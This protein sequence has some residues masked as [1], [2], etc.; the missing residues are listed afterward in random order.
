MLTAEFG[1]SGGKPIEHGLVVEE[2]DIE[3]GAGVSS[4]AISRR[5]PTGKN[6]PE[7]EEERDQS[8]GGWRRGASRRDDEPTT[9]PSAITAGTMLGFPFSF[10]AA[11]AN[12]AGGAPGMMPYSSA[13]GYG[14][15]DQSQMYRQQ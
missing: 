1:G 12:N 6:A 7:R 2:P 9:G 14:L 4:K 8:S 11:A 10:G 15:P 5:M 13:P 3:I